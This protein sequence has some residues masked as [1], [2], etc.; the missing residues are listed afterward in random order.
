MVL[1]GEQ[2]EEGLKGHRCGSERGT[3]GGLKGFN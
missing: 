3:I 1:K 2:L